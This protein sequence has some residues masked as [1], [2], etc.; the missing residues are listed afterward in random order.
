MHFVEKGL[1]VIEIKSLLP[2][3]ELDGI[4]SAVERKRIKCVKILE[5]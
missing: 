4:L 5:K 3:V 2:V 1:N